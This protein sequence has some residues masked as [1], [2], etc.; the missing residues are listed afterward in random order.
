VNFSQYIS[1]L[2]RREICTQH[3]YGL[4]SF[5]KHLLSQT[6]NG[7]KRVQKSIWIF[8]LE[9][10]TERFEPSSRIFLIGEQPNPWQLLHRQDKMSRHRG[11]ELRRRYELLGGTSLLSLE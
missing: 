3:I 1:V 8:K 10:I 4:I 9:L 11:A 6:L 2:H 7:F 5:L